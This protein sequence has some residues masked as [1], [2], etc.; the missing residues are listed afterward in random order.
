MLWRPRTAWDGG[1]TA[2]QRLREQGGAAWMLVRVVY[3][4][5][6][7]AVLGQLE[8]WGGFLKRP[9]SDPLW[10]VVWVGV[11]PWPWGLG[12]ILWASLL[13]AVA[14]AF[15][16]FPRWLRAAAAVSFL[17]QLAALN[18]FG[19][20]SHIY[21]GILLM[22]LALAL[23]PNL[24]ARRALGLRQAAAVVVGV[25]FAQA[26]FLA[27]YTMSGVGK[28]GQG[29]AQ[30]WHGK[31]GS[32]HPDSLA[33]HIAQQMIDTGNEP[34]LARAFLQAGGWLWPLMLG[35][36]YFQLASLWA[37]G[38]P[39]LH[40]SW[41]LLLVVFHILSQFTL[42]VG[43]DQNCFLLILLFGCTPFAPCRPQWKRM[44]RDLPG[45]GCLFAGWPFRPEGK[46]AS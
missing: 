41:A 10:P 3:A 25:Q 18:S 21:H 16:P 27:T 14:A 43:F 33:L 4:F 20:I 37:A 11:L 39:S 1:N 8:N 36:V 15:H 23:I 29:I 12:I 40:R 9:L 13:L 5:Q 32:F 42:S 28:L 24:P 26:L 17:L 35:A 31:P 38:R 44:L 6:A 45:F 22:A 19:K 34:L 46:A 2:L 30:A 7:F